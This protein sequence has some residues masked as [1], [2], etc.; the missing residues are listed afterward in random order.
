MFQ[1]DV[2]VREPIGAVRKCLLSYC[3]QGVGGYGLMQAVGMRDKRNGVIVGGL[4][5][6]SS[7][8]GL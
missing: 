5:P 3:D 4:L 6:Q 7:R 8:M 2:S 1:F